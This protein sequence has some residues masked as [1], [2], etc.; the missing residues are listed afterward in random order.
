MVSLSKPQH[1]Y[2]G[3]ADDHRYEHFSAII[4]DSRLAS[5]SLSDMSVSEAAEKHGTFPSD[6]G[7]F[8]EHHPGP[9]LKFMCSFGGRILPRPGDGK[10]RYAG[11]DTR[12]VS[13]HRHIH[14][15][16]LMLKMTQLYDQTVSLKYQL[17][18]ED[19]DALISVSS[20]EDLENMM[21][22][23]ERLEAGEG[24]SRFRIFLFPQA[25]Y[26]VV[27]LSGSSDRSNTEKVYL[28]AINGM[29]ETSLKHPDMATV[30]SSS[31]LIGLEVPDGSNNRAFS[32][33][34]SV[35]MLETP[36]TDSAAASFVPSVPLGVPLTTEHTLT[37]I[38]SAPPSVPSSPRS[39]IG[40]SVIS[41]HYFSDQ[42]SKAA[43][44]PLYETVLNVS[45]QEAEGVGAVTSSV[46]SQH[47]GIFRNP[48]PNRRAD[49]LTKVQK[50]AMLAFG[51]PGDQA[52][53]SDQ[54]SMADAIVSTHGFMPGVDSYGIMPGVDSFYRQMPPQEQQVEL[55]SSALPAETDLENHLSDLPLDLQLQETVWRT[56]LEA[57]W[58]GYGMQQSA[59][60]MQA[61]QEA[62]HYRQQIVSQDYPSAGMSAYET[63]VFKDLEQSLQQDDALIG[64]L[65]YDSIASQT[66]VNPLDIGAVSVP[67]LS[68]PFWD[69]TTKQDVAS[70]DMLA[71][72]GVTGGFM[73]KP[74]ASRTVQPHNR[75]LKASNIPLNYQEK[76]QFV[77]M[78]NV[79]QKN[80]VDALH[81]KNEAL[82]SQSYYSDGLTGNMLPLYPN[83]STFQ[84]SSTFLK[85]H[86]MPRGGSHDHLHEESAVQLC[87]QD[88]LQKMCNGLEETMG[89][90]TQMGQVDM[91]K[92]LSSDYGPSESVVDDP[93]LDNLATSFANAAA[94][95]AH[96][97]ALNASHEYD[98]L[99]TTPAHLRAG[100]ML[101]K[102][103]LSES[104]QPDSLTRRSESDGLSTQAPTQVG[105]TI[106]NASGFPLHVTDTQ[107]VNH[108]A[109]PI[110]HKPDDKAGGLISVETDNFLSPFPTN[111]VPNISRAESLFLAK[112]E[113]GQ[114]IGDFKSDVSTSNDS[115]G[116]FSDD[117]FK[118]TANLILDSELTRSASGNT[119]AGLWNPLDTSDVPFMSQQDS[120]RSLIDDDTVVPP[121]THI[122]TS[123]LAVT[124][125]ATGLDAF[126]A[127]SALSPRT[128]AS[129]GSSMT[130]PSLSI[131][132]DTFSASGQ[133]V[134]SLNHGNIV[135]S[136]PRDGSLESV[137]VGAS[138]FDLVQ[139]SNSL[140][141]KGYFPK[142]DSGSVQELGNVKHKEE[143]VKGDLEH[144]EPILYSSPTLSMQNWEDTLANVELE[145]NVTKKSLPVD[146][147]LDGGKL[148]IEEK[149]VIFQEI[150]T[151]SEEADKDGLRVN[152]TMDLAAIAEKEAISRGLQT[153]KN[154]DLEQ[155]RELGSGT[156]GTVYHG[157][158]RGT[159]VA[160]KR[161]K[162][163]CFIG[164]PSEKQQLIADFW[165]EACLLGQLHHPNVVAFYGVVP[166]GPGGTLATVTEYMVN[167]S[168]KQVL[169]KKERT[170]DRRKRLLISMD[171]A[172][173]MEYL[174]GK[175][176]IH[177]DLKCENLLVNLR[178]PQRPICKVG[179]LG[180]SKVKHQTM[181]S[182]GV[183][184]TLPWMA[185]ELLNGSSS[186]VS[187]KVDVF[188]FGIVMWELLT[189]EEPY[190]NMHYG[191]IIGGIVNNTLRPPIPSWCDPSW[192]SLMERCWS[193]DPAL[194]PAFPEIA[195]ELRTMATSANLKLN[196]KPQMLIAPG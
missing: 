183:R 105:I 151:E 1:R 165:Q 63:A 18:D 70:Q 126:T 112:M 96:V 127:A 82:Q 101:S 171:A 120:N 182:G 100:L 159:D 124:S 68:V 189:G 109:I 161:I 186:L 123:V 148:H 81:G 6:S 86:G 19:L 24:S 115:R 28:D 15:A 125:S 98:P 29:S 154:T 36:F 137:Q 59:L 52:Y 122:H 11:G 114:C 95:D 130:S 134:S 9:R 13:L 34:V 91:R 191:A 139:A 121:F 69:H 117:A 23:Y 149:E 85:E 163:S 179:D 67:V 8:G 196:K 45:Y 102:A 88:G 160:I 47:D 35:A 22:E 103:L 49:P 181:V 162:S 104:L 31:N 132:K 54:V 55:G 92:G 178:D 119:S 145:E 4:G 150:K 32:E 87:Y 27:H 39:Q 84:D 152:M 177:F 66:T 73:Q 7:S 89:V 50:D 194:R 2:G 107:S 93:A 158:W 5:G 169:H 133:V 192:R 38:L 128:S 76:L 141:A 153:I 116:H 147:S 170:I 176:I 97:T 51:T 41:P 48:E 140:E 57:R 10:L 136:T 172:F 118:I 40:P 155:L 3:S 190:A 144:V 64:Q 65:P 53:R 74:Y 142:F 78:E 195:A 184:G 187:E 72:Q 30:S 143:D 26:D 173:G 44:G 188:S 21:E 79:T 16:D 129:A 43:V 71:P 138:P 174:H 113:E 146:K 20:D 25:E 62:S 193:A 164:R 106:S 175:N 56:P 58:E 42:Q 33:N 168:L 77:N 99:E 75:V 17:P 14:F 12:I 110:H 60:D 131:T 185:P 157:K 167:G 37:R 83:A 135:S 94:N 46:T 61:Q 166:D 111:I 80:S 180:L 156:F 108:V 90:W